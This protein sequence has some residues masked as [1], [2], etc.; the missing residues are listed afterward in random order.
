MAGWMAVLL[1]A[2]D[3]CDAV[4]QS[5]ETEFLLP[6]HDDFQAH[7][8]PPPPDELARLQRALARGR[9]GRLVLQ[10][11]V[12]D[13]EDRLAARFTGRYVAQRD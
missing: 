5:G 2:G 11:E 10:V 7:V 13:G 8:L 6:I 9:P 3:G 4:I 12:R 1:A